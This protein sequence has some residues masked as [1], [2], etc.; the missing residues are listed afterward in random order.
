MNLE[1]VR[2]LKQSLAANVLPRIETTITARA[3]GQ[4]ARPIA[5]ASEPPRSVALGVARKGKND[6]QLA[7]RVQQRAPLP[8]DPRSSH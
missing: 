6:F 2:E 5:R 8:D 7:V 3:F 1:S 4:S